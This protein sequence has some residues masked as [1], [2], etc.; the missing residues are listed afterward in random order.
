M[1][2]CMHIG[3]TFERDEEVNGVKMYLYVCHDCQTGFHSSLPP[4]R[5]DYWPDDTYDSE[6]EWDIF[7]D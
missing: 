1:L 3:R 2:D 6:T 7:I 4:R 5:E